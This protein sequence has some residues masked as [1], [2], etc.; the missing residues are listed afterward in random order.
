MTPLSLQN[1]EIINLTNNAAAAPRTVGL[2]NAGQAEEVTNDDSNSDLT[3]TGLAATVAQL[4]VFDTDQDTTFSYI[5][6]AGTQTVGLAVDNVT[7]EVILGVAVAPDITLAGIETINLV[8]GDGTTQANT[9]DLFANAA[10]TIDINGVADLTMTLGAGTTSVSLIDGSEA[11][12][13][14]AITL[15]NQPGVLTTTAVSVY[16]GAGDD[17]L[18]VSAETTSNVSVAGNAGDDTIAMGS[19]AHALSVNDSIDGGT[20]TNTLSTTFASADAVDGATNQINNIQILELTTALGGAL[21][22]VGV[23]STIVEVDVEV[24]AALTTAASTVTG[25]AGTFTLDLGTTAAGNVGA[26]A[27]AVTVSDGAAVVSTTDTAVITNLS[28]NSTT[29]SNVNVFAG[30]NITSA[31]YENLELNTGT[32]SPAPQTIG[33]LTITADSTSAATSLDI[34]GN[35]QVTIASLTNNSSGLMT[36][37]AS[38]LSVTTTANGLT[39]T[40]NATVASGTQSITGSAGID[41]ITVVGNYASTILGGTG[42]DVITGGTAADSI[43]GGEGNDNLTGS[44]GNDT[45]RGEAGDDTISSIVA[46]VVSIDGGAGNDTV[47]LAAT[48]AATD[49]VNGGDGIDT[50]SVTAEITGI[51]G[52]GVTNFEILQTA[53]AAADMSATANNTGWTT[54]FAD[55]A[56]VAVTNASSTLNTYQIDNSATT[57]H[58]F[59]RLTDTAT[60]ALTLQTTQVD[61]TV[62]ASSWTLNSR[63]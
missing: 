19:V 5:S 61:N 39:L 57:T 7:P 23:D 48:L 25:G 20:G 55:A 3:I 14:L 24:A 46:G 15:I 1:I 2:V 11:T 26:L 22:A 34:D 49:V 10:N 54:V 58:S 60:N 52:V 56:S 18:N 51:T 33:T 42:A 41:T 53:G 37:D 50:L 40:T 47:S 17:T 29:G 44:G 9:F 16:G 45:I 30:Q 27:H 12:G 36:V 8:S 62:A 4:N 13:D 63:P 43:H 35:D 21:S 31:G 28:V 32:A 59:G 6:T 38:G